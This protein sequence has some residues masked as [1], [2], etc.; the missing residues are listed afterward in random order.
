VNIG[1]SEALLV[2]GCLLFVAA[3]LSGLMKGTVLSISVLSVGLGLILAETGVVEVSPGDPGITDL[4]VVALALTLFADGLFVERELLRKH[5]GPAAR[6][7]VI[8]MPLTLVLIGL[9]A[10]GLFPSLTWAEAGLLGAAL[11]ATDPVVTSSVV[12]SRKVPAMI[13][14]TLNLESGLNDGL[15]LPFVLFFL[16]L[17][18]GSGDAGGEVLKLVGEVAVGALIGVAIGWFGGWLHD[19]VPGGLTR[20]YEGIYAISL[21]LMA[22]GLAEVTFGNG[23]IAAFVAGITLGASERK[24]PEAFVEFSENASAIAQVLTFFVFGSLIVATGYDGSVLALLAFIVFAFVIARPAAVLPALVKTK[25]P[26]DQRLFI[27]WFGPKGVASMLFALYILNSR[28]SDSS[29]VFAIAAFTIIASIVV[30]G[31]TETVGTRW[32]AGR[33]KSKKR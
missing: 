22:Y 19:R 33:A 20:T 16:V 21:G 29:F 11:C 24:V 10:K 18:D 3:A 1:F 15:A 31:L 14:H 17:V 25:L 28:T 26:R 7:L 32:L 30:H 4:I 2:I 6:A 8:A 23:L 27:A 5:W 13:R 12:T 9:A